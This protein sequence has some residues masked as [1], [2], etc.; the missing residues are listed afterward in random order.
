MSRQQNKTLLW[1]IFFRSKWIGSSGT[2]SWPCSKYKLHNI[3]QNVVWCV[4]GGWEQP[5]GAD[6]CRAAVEKPPHIQ[7]PNNEATVPTEMAGPSGRY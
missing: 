2:V 1:K 6:G 4:G 5:G 3:Y 7:R